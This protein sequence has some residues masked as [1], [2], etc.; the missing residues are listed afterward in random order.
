MHRVKV[1]QEVIDWTIERRGEL[2]PLANFD[3]AATA[4]VIVDMQGFFI[5][6]VPMARSIV[7]NINRL[8]TGVRG[9]LVRPRTP[10]KSTRADPEPCEGF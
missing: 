6:M 8:A 5:D 10:W 4:L 9:A 1:P 3:P 7:A 2:H